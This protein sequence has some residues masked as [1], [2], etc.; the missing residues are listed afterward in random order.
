[1]KNAKKYRDRL[2]CRFSLC[3]THRDTVAHIQLPVQI[4]VPVQNSRPDS[5]AAVVV[6]RKFFSIEKLRVVFCLQFLLPHFMSI[7]AKRLIQY[8]ISR[9]K[10]TLNNNV[11][12]RKTT[13]HLDNHV[14]HW[15]SL[16]HTH[17]HAEP[18]FGRTYFK[19]PPFFATKMLF[20]GWLVRHCA[21]QWNGIDAN[22]WI[23]TIM[24]PSCIGPVLRCISGQ[25]YQQ[26]LT[27][28]E[29]VRLA[30]E[31]KLT[32]MNVFSHPTITRTTVMPNRPTFYGCNWWKQFP[33]S[34]IYVFEVFISALKRNCILT[35][36][37]L[38]VKKVQA[39]K[40]SK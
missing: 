11:I 9:W 21:F 7:T 6:L 35:Y 32:R 30:R 39:I 4:F 29:S 16:M 8:G 10:I 23:V 24:A 26:R 1:M 40:R 12:W 20:N 33:V 37:R 25:I 27:L 22:I 13:I 38:I 14:S 36:N 2:R 15:S 18:S 34:A 3:Q 17:R 28:P 5:D 19:P 31:T